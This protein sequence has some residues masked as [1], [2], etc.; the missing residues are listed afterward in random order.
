MSND[1][2]PPKPAPQSDKPQKY[3]VRF[4]KPEDEQKILDFY[5][6]NAHQNV[7]KREA[8]I[9]KNRIEDGSVVLIEDAQG[10]IVA[11]SISYPHKTTD[12]DGDEHIKW[13]E[14]GST[15]IVLNG[16]PGLFDAMIAMQVLRTFL[17]EPPEDRLVA[18]MH[19]EPVQKMA[20]KLGWR[21]FSAPEDLIRMQKKSLN[22][23]D[24]SAAPPDVNWFHMGVEGLPVVAN[25]MVQALQ[26]PVLENR[27][28]GEKIELDFSKSKF[29]TVFKDEI[30]ALADR[31]LGD[32][33]TP[34][35]SASIAK[36]S[37]KWMKA[38]FK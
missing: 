9:L 22:Q 26:P 7:R 10:Q 13:Q 19:T 2:L 33:M 27:K 1:N 8:D 20:E 12:K 6:L 38:Y 4:S 24:Q 15:R 3:F 23:N 21:R 28:T 34:D 35:Y 17:V 31:D 32:H 11:A 25:W 18:R 37:E 14:V 30:M 36:R 5:D 16:Y 29:F